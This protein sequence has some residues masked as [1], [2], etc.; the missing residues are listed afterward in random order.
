MK[1]KSIS[2]EIKKINGLIARKIFSE[3]KELSK[4]LD[5]FKNIL[6]KK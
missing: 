2:F 1:E 5:I 4:I 3:S 6:I